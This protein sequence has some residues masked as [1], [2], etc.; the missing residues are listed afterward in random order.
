MFADLV[1]TIYYIYRVPRGAADRFL[2]VTSAASDLYR[3]HGALDSFMMRITAASAQ[4]ACAGLKD[5]VCVRDD[6][7]L[8]LG[9]DSF[10][11]ADE[12]RKLLAVIDADPDIE[13][14]FQAVQKII[15][16]STV[17]RWE[18]TSAG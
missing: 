13:K 3:R 14:L 1:H 16:V 8:F 15:D 12:C 5:V 2:E 7:E 17:V 18:A 4:Y 9:I 6:E 11:H 10:R